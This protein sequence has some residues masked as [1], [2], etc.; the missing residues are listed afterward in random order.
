MMHVKTSAQGCLQVALRYRLTLISLFCPAAL[1]GMGIALPHV[2]NLQ[3]VNPEI[4]IQEVRAFQCDQRGLLHLWRE[5]GLGEVGGHSSPSLPT[6]A[7]S[8]VQGQPGLGMPPCP[9]HAMNQ[10]QLDGK[11]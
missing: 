5:A 11:F 6:R 3:Y 4:F 8:G 1:L 9:D 10:L 2:V 7:H